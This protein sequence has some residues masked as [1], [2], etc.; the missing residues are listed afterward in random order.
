MVLG[1]VSSQN[2]WMDSVQDDVTDI[3][4]ELLTAQSIKE[5]S[6]TWCLVR[7]GQFAKSV[8]SIPDDVTGI[9]D[10]LETAQP[11]N[12]EAVTWCQVRLVP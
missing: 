4:D 9:S 6:D 2:V 1:Q 8:G 3:S 11:I 10:A 5:D 12:Q 7:L